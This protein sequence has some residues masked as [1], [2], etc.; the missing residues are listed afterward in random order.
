MLT[1]AGSQPFGEIPHGAVRNCPLRP[2]ED[3]ERAVQE[4]SALTFE[5]AMALATGERRS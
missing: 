3:G 4:G 2:Q 5:E 1:G